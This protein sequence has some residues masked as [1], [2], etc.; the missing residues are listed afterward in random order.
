MVKFIS[1]C[2]HK[3]KKMSSCLKHRH[4]ITARGIAQAQTSPDGF[5]TQGEL[6]V[7]RVRA[8]VQNRL[9]QLASNCH[10]N[11]PCAKF[12]AEENSVDGQ[13]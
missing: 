5:K 9:P 2:L 1:M 11:I 13:F 6:R 4:G 12:E 10:N 7:A 8:C 3:G